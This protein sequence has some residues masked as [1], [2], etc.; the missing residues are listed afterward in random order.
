[1]ARWKRGQSGNP[2]G[3]PKGAL[4]KSTTEIKQLLA[5]R[6]D[7]EA[8]VMKLQAL[9]KRGNVRA[10]ELLLAYR[11]GR[12]AGNEEDTR[13]N[14]P[15]VDKL[16]HRAGESLKSLLGEISAE[17]I[18]AELQRRLKLSSQGVRVSD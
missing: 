15:D 2:N 11:Y 16:S 17:E 9:A 3:R 18:S 4:N 10:A 6:I 14:Q 13:V 7:Y 12:P 1:M 8:L 5:E